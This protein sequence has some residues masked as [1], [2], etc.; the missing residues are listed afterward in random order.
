MATSLEDK[1]R[2][3]Q[4]QHSAEQDPVKKQELQKQITKL[5]LR[6]ELEKLK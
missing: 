3:K 2:I 1:I 4:L 6:L 5:R